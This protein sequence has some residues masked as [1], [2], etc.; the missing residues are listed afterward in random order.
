[1]IQGQDPCPFAEGVIELAPGLV[2]DLRET[3]LLVQPFLDD[4]KEA[5]SVASGLKMLDAWEAEVRD[6]RDLAFEVLQEQCERKPV[7]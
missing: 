6:S 4:P 5:P 2:E 3:K 7:R 1:M